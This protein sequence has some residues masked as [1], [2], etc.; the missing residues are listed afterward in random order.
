MTHEID[1]HIRGNGQPTVFIHSLGLDH[2]LWDFCIEELSATS[3]TLSYDLP[4]HGNNPPP[5]HSYEIKNLS[6]DLVESLKRHGIVKANFVGLSIGGMIAQHLAANNPEIVEKLVLI[7]TTPTYSEEWKKNWAERASIARTR[8]VKVMREKLLEAF[9]TTDF[10]TQ[11]SAEIEYCRSAIN[12]ISAEG[13]ALACEA[14][15]LGEMEKYAPL[16]VANTLIMCGDQDNILFKEAVHWFNENIQN[17]KVEWLSP[18][19]HVSPLECQKDFIM[20]LKKFL[21]L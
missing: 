12:S 4:G 9:F 1:F 20:H 21:E 2:K 19:Q 14:L 15:A 7:D 18:A 10:L 11:D 16:I 13:Y 17:T 5:S 8:G 6:N 3:K